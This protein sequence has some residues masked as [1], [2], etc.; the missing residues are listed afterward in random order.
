MV[1]ITIYNV[2]IDFVEL[3]FMFLYQIKICL[4]ALTN[5]NFHECMIIG[6]YIRRENTTL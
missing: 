6:N 3:L 1:Y 5:W 4:R 2:C